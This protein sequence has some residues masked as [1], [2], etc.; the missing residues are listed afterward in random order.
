[1]TDV[2]IKVREHGP[3]RDHRAVRA[4]R[5]GRERVRAA[6][7]GDRRRSAA[8]GGPA[9]SRSAT[10]RT[11]R[12]ASR[13]RSGLPGE[14]PRGR[15]GA[16]RR[17][18]RG[19]GARARRAEGGRGARPA[20]R[21]RR[22]PHRPL[23]RLGRRPVRLRADR[24]RP[25]GRG[26]RR[27]RRR[28]RHVAR[29]RR[30][31]RH[32]LLAPVPRVRPLSP[33][34]ASSL[35]L[36][37]REQQN[38]GYLPDGTTRLSRDGEPI[39]HFMGTS[40]FA[41]YTVMPE[42]ALAKVSP[43]A[44]LEGAALFACGLSTGLGAAIKTA[45]VEPGSTC[46]VFGAGHGRARRGRRLPAPGRGA[47]H[48]RRPLRGAA[49]AG[50]GPGRDRDD[51]R[52]PRHRRADRRGDRRLRRRLHLRGDRQRRGDAAGGR[53]GAD[54]LG[55]LHG[56]GRRRQGR[57]ARH[58]AALPDHRPP[59]RGLVVRRDQGARRGA[60]ARRPLARR[61]D[62]RRARSSRT[63]SRSTRSTAASS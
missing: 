2:V 45:A 38:H 19:A 33:P 49:R 32:A 13:H 43:E 1:M 12:S 21:V 35:C 25:R 16:V 34:A 57:D 40:T 36:A 28:R 61:R 9:P 53:V 27:A 48:L 18:A 39:R 63:R 42:I 10:R 30:P 17:S 46:V 4:G 26:R 44:P 56:R 29:A 15:A 60:A 8:A 51:A 41:E 14:D 5:R 58:R 7:G 24:A 50:E 3:Y 47:D 54:G 55:A 37:I 6:R 62:R 11:A 31:R 22:L 59:G 23:H 52:R 20:R